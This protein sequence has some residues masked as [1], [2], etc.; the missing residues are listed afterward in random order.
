[1]LKLLGL[2]FLL[3]LIVAVAGYNLGWFTFTSTQDG[4]TSHLSVV[5]DK[6]KFESDRQLAKRKLSE[7]GG[8]PD[9]TTAPPAAR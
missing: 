2:F 9:K 3:A 7:L 4:Q 6:A 8:R 1:M 5:V